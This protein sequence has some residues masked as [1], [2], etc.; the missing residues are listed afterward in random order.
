MSSQL[1]ALRTAAARIGTTLDEDTTCGEL[2]REAARQAG[3]TAALLRLTTQSGV[4][5]E[6]VSGNPAV[7]P[8]ARWAASV[9][10]EPPA[11]GDN[12]A[13]RPAPGGPRQALCVPLATNGH[14]YGTLVCARDGAPFT[15]LETA[16]LAFL[17]E[18]AASHIRHAREHD[19]V[20]G[21][22]GKLQRALL[23]EP[24]PQP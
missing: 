3:G 4:E 2:T 23:T 9:T 12:R 8:D 18:H 22:V 5:Y 19:Q 21:I 10:Q 16:F 11:P 20:S 14:D 15:R 7:L 13:A 6:A 24:A 17:A 1:S